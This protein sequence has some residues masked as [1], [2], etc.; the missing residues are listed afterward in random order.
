[1]CIINCDR[2]LARYMQLS[3]VHT[4]MYIMR[5]LHEL[6]DYVEYAVRNMQRDVEKWNRAS[7]TGLALSTQN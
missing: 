3:C 4:L 7:N 6:R 2:R 5:H 1:M